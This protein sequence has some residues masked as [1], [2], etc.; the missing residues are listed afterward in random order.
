[1]RVAITGGTGFVGRR[2]ARGLVAR[3]HQAVLVARGKDERD[4][5]IY[6]LSKASF[7]KSDL[8]DPEE[9]RRAFL[10][11]DAVAHCA[12]INRE[13]GAQ[14]YLRVPVRGTK[15]VVKAARLAAVGK[16][17]LLNFL[18]ARPNCG[19]AYH[20]SKW[21]AEEI[22]RGSRL[23]YTIFK[24]G[25]I[26]GRGD[27]MLDHISHALYTFPIFG[28]VGMKGKPIG[29]GRSRSGKH[30]FVSRCPSLEQDREHYRAGRNRTSAKPSAASGRGHRKRMPLAVQAVIAKVPECTTKI[31][32]LSLAQ[33]RISSEGIAEA[34]PACDTL[35]ADLL[36]ATR[37]T[38]EQIRNGLPDPRTIRSARSALLQGVHGG[39]TKKKGAVRNINPAMP[40]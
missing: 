5:S 39:L 22:V 29:C 28:L 8:S 36:P 32:L 11:C 24:A 21:A 33:L 7:V 2:L 15:H 1:M 4:E 18:R 6:T 10:G 31:A 9:L 27:H 40:F 20:E 34:L 25:G 38:A 14:T 26:Y 3:G 13:L 30:R 23:S 12:G 37:F 35:P 16:I 19:S 17:V